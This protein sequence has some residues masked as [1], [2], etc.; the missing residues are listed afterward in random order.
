MQ[1]RQQS[2]RPHHVV[3]TGNNPG[4]IPEIGTSRV[5]L[6][7]TPLA[8]SASCI[9]QLRQLYR[10]W[11]RYLFPTCFSRAV[12]FRGCTH[13][14][15]VLTRQ[16]QERTYISHEGMLYGPRH[17]RS[18]FSSGLRENLALIS[19][20]VSS[21]I[22]TKLCRQRSIS[23]QVGVVMPR[24]AG[25]RLEIFSPHKCWEYQI[26]A[27][28]GQNWYPNHQES[29]R[30]VRDIDLSTIPTI[31]NE[32]GI[33]SSRMSCEELNVAHTKIISTGQL[34]PHNPF[35]SS[36]RGGYRRGH[37]LES[38]IPDIF[39]SYWSCAAE[40]VKKF[41]DA[42]AG[43]SMQRTSEVNRYEKQFKPP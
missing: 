24:L 32:T 38:Y 19:S 42:K 25:N 5:C 23:P 16:T 14:N 11:D 20:A 26:E 2:Q 17:G 7:R 3:C 37:C 43:S 13:R 40:R 1:L 41:D 9:T 4:N 22:T 36:V 12:Y 21:S 28:C 27:S 31:V 30:R 34:I 33:A 15:T 18:W 8:P 6:I 35:L 29:D 39:C 10:L